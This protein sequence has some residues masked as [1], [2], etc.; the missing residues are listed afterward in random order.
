MFFKYEITLHNYR[1]NRP[2][3]VFP[4][5]NLNKAVKGLNI[6]ATCMMKNRCHSTE[7]E[8]SKQTFLIVCL[9]LP[10]NTVTM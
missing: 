1:N 10:S 4:L 7:V 2:C 8:I 5:S 9:L 6:L 3:F